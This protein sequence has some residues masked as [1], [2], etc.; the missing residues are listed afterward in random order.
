MFWE[1]ITTPHLILCVEYI[2]S[3]PLTMFRLFHFLL[4]FEIYFPKHPNSC[5]T[6][7]EVSFTVRKTMDLQK[8]WAILHYTER[9]AS[10]HFGHV[11]GTKICNTT[12]FSDS[13]DEDKHDSANITIKAHCCVL[14]IIY[15]IKDNQNI[16]GKTRFKR[17]FIQFLKVKWLLYPAIPKPLQ[18]IHTD[19]KCTK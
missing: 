11:G 5:W 3:W 1:T 2:L 14:K 4:F 8:S 18:I 19:R 16:E 7:R 6:H 17:I 15:R 9:H 10:I 12:S 13:A